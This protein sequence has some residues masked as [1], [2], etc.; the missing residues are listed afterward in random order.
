MFGLAM[1]TVDWLELIASVGQNAIIIASLW[2]VNW[3]TPLYAIS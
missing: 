3:Q 1:Q 2:C